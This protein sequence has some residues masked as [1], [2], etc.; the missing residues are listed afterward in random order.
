MEAL[1]PLQV[2]MQELSNQRNAA[3]DALVNAKVQEHI[4]R[5]RIAELEKKLAD[6]E[7][8]LTPEAPE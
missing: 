2:A 6:A 7:K 3:F 5:E 4:L 1:T 8:A